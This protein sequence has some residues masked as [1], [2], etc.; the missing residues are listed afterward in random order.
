LTI[1][2]VIAL[3]VRPGDRSLAFDA[4]VLALGG[5]GLLLLVHTTRTALP[6]P[7]RP[8]G[9]SRFRDDYE[10]RS[11]L[12]ELARTEREVALA[13]GTAFD[14]HY[15]LRPLLREVASHRLA[16]RRGIDLDLEPDAAAAALG[17]E[18][19]EVVRP[20]RPR[21]KHHFT[22]GLSL[23]EIRAIVATIERI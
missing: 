23:G 5:L 6:E 1:A 14:V 7:P 2:V 15:R 3:V 20:D 16:T 11:P 13:T 9:R 22:A 19:W 12:A 4:Y 21:P 8:R 10:A 18:A 17:E